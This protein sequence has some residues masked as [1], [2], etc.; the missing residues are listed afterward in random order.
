[1]RRRVLRKCERWEIEED[2]DPRMNGDPV[3]SSCTLIRMYSRA[4]LVL[5]FYSDIFFRE[6]ISLNSLLALSRWKFSFYPKKNYQRVNSECTKQNL[7]NFYD[8]YIIQIAP[9]KWK[10]TQLHSIV[11]WRRTYNFQE[12]QSLAM[13][14]IVSKFK[15]LTSFWMQVILIERKCSI[16][17]LGYGSQI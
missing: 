7:D 13:H 15:I 8:I 11:C 3:P 4:L 14:E 17:T 9:R 12:S 2:N 10:K 6:R 1:M 16:F 5:F